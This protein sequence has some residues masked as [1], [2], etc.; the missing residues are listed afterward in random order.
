MIPEII[1]S[2]DLDGRIIFTRDPNQKAWLPSIGGKSYGG[3]SKDR[4]VVF[5]GGG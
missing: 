1:T 2:R 4:F 5:Y 3:G